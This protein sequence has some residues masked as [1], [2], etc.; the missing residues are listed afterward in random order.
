MATTTS[1]WT[2]LIQQFLP[3]FTQPAGVIFTRLILGW[4]LCN[5]RRTVTG[6]LPFA[7]PLGEHAHDAFHRIF[8]LVQ[9]GVTIG[10]G[11]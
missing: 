9:L 10:G 11:V 7:D 4:V 1:A 8:G 6:M 3:F 2:S 5:V